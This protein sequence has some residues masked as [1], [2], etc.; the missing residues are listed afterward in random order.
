[1][2]SHFKISFTSWGCLGLDQIWRSERAGRGTRSR[3]GGM[4]LVGQGPVQ[5]ATVDSSVI[6]QSIEQVG[7]L[8][9]N[10]TAINNTL[11]VF[12]SHYFF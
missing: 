1:M 9:L 2:S 8:T 11:T 6:K 12:C 5:C 7:V 10:K 4:R 3:V